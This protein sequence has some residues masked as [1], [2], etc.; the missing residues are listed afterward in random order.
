M[1]LSDVIKKGDG[2]PTAS[3]FA[4]AEGIGLDTTNG[5]T[6]VKTATNSII[7]QGNIVIGNTDSVITDGVQNTITKSDGTTQDLVAKNGLNGHIIDAHIKL[8]DDKLYITADETKILPIDVVRNDNFGYAVAIDS[9]II[10]VGVPS[11]ESV[12]GAAYMF[13][14]NGNQIHKLQASD[15]EIDDNFGYSVA[16]DGDKIVVGAPYE[17]TGASDAGAVYIFD[18]YGNQLYK[19]QASDKEINDNFGY[20]VAISGDKIVVGAPNEDTGASAAGSVYIFD[21]D[22]NQLHKIQSSDI[23]A[24][25]SFGYSVAIDGDKIVVGALYEDTGASDAGAAYIF[26]TDGNQLHKLQ[27]S[28]KEIQ[29]RF[30]SSVAISGDIVVVGAPFE[31]TGASDAGAAYIFDTNGNQ[32]HKLQASDKAE[33]YKFGYSVAIEGDKIV[34]GSY[35]SDKVVGFTGMAY[36]FDTNGNQIY[37]IKASDK[38]AGDRFGYI[39]DID[40]GKIATGATG[41]D[42]DGNDTGA[43]Y[44]YKGLI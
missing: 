36:I 13:D 8:D 18:I 2:A 25:D 11:K 16:I 21:T 34:V 4:S 20:A 37:E 31:D 1:K 26:D 44:I 35:D 38:Q 6:Y 40:D 10:V 24:V 28:D 43:A 19:L 15:K 29:D 41:V 22:G 12:T 23:E 42:A 17:D 7:R 30:G 5:V 39:V 14:T 9:N 32:L 3:A 27:A 33:D